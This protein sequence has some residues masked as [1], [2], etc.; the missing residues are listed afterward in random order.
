MISQLNNIKVV[1]DKLF[2]HLYVERKLKNGAFECENFPDIKILKGM[3]ISQD[4]FFVA[5]NVFTRISP[6]L[7]CT[8]QKKV[9]SHLRIDPRDWRL[10]EIRGWKKV[11]SDW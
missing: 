6:V 4:R 1:R 11:S 7:L 8:T 10:E 9:D 3:L 5:T 2:R